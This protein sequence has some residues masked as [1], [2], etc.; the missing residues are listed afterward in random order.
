MKNSTIESSVIGTLQK[1]CYKILDEHREGLSEYEILKQAQKESAFPTLKGEN[2]VLMFREHFLLMHCLY[3]LQ[4]QLSRE[5]KYWLHINPVKTIL[6]KTN[7]TH[8][9]KSEV[10]ESSSHEALKKYYLDWA[11]FEST[12]KDDVDKLFDD[13]WR[14][15]ARHL[16]GDEAFSILDLDINANQ[17]EITT[18]YRVLAAKHHPD[19]GGDKEAFI[20]IRGAY[21]T[22]KAQ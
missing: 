17:K 18:R 14:D 22:L 10:S 2:N 20:R 9:N 21:E 3:K 11:H 1:Y 12:K 5:K 15:Y 16:S 8:G 13:F 7:K 6:Q 4:Q 19:K